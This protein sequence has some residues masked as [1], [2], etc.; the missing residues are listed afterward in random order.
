MIGDIKIYIAKFWKQLW[1]FHEYK[2]DHRA[3]YLFT[4][5]IYECE[6]CGRTIGYNPGG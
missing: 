2:Q 1:C 3:F 5:T 4:I 6:K